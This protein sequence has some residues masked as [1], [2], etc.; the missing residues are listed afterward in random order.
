MTIAWEGFGNMLDDK[1]STQVCPINALGAMGKGLALTMRRAYP[2]LH[3]HYR[4]AYHPQFSEVKD[5]YA[6]ASLL[7]VVRVHDVSILLFCTKLDWHDPS[8]PELVEGN[9][10]RLAAQWKELGIEKLAIPLIGAGEGRLPSAWVRSKIHEY[11]G[12]LELPVRL[13]LGK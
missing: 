13:Y 6:R 7:T 1:D 12:P 4:D 10:Q 5:I 8:P 11:L 9:L 3:V 2:D